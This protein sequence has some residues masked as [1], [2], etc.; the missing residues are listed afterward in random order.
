MKKSILLTLVLASSA[1][2]S[3]FKPYN[4]R[5]INHSGGLVTVNSKKNI[6]NLPS[7]L[8]NNSDF[9]VRV[10]DMNASACFTTGPE[11]QK[12]KQTIQFCAPKSIAKT[13][14][15]KAKTFEAAGFET[16]CDPFTIQIVNNSGGIATILKESNTSLAK[17]ITIKQGGV[18]KPRVQAGA[19]AQFRTG[20]EGNKRQFEITFYTKTGEN[21]Q[22]TLQQGGVFRGNASAQDIVIHSH[23]VRADNGNGKHK[24]VKYTKKAPVK[25]VKNQPK[26]KATSAKK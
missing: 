17:N 24:T 13:L 15:L 16:K 23:N 5:I 11:D 25:S 10:Q 21:P 20:P 12:T 26:T 7:Q 9:T 19:S 1:Y 18:V 22:V 2:A 3:H 8:P 14:V 4:V 6:S